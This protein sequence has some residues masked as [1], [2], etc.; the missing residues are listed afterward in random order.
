MDSTRND[1]YWVNSFPVTALRYGIE[2]FAPDVWNGTRPN[3]AVI[4]PNVGSNLGWVVP[5]SS[6]VGAAAYAAHVQRIP[7]IAFS[8][9]THGNLEYSEPSPQRS[10]IYAQLATRLVSRIVQGGWPYLPEDVF[11]N[12]NLPRIRPGCEQ[13]TDVRWVLSRIYPGYFQPADIHWCGS[14]RLPEEVEVLKMGCYAS[15][16]IGDAKDKSTVS[17]ERQGIVLTKLHDML[18]CMP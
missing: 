16:S 10:I 15:I 4:G 3:L 5:Y 7:A 1:L 12:V 14:D 11:L 13:V 6:T 9:A 2:R 8:G 17:D 18:T